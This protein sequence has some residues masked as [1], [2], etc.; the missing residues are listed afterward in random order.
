M[1]RTGSMFFQELK[2][3]FEVFGISKKEDIELIKKGKVWVRK[4]GRI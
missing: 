1:G 4:N 3:S 2:D